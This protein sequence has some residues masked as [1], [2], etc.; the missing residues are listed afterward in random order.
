MKGKQ[1]V[2]SF[3]AKQAYPF[4][5]RISYGELLWILSCQKAAPDTHGARGNIVWQ[6]YWFLPLAGLHSALPIP[7]DLGTSCPLQ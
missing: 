2:N 3:D 5:N 7:F 4:A 1:E 6:T